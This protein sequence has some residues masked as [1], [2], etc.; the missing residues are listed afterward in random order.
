MA[1]GHNCLS[2]MPAD[3]PTAYL[4]AVK[5]LA[6]RELSVAQMRAR[7]A[8]RDHPPADV[9]RAVNLLLE[10]GAL[11]DAR[12][13]RAYA[14]TALRTKGRG[15]LRI[16]R[17]LH[18]IGIEKDVAGEALGEIFGEVDER[19]LIRKAI[20]KKLRGHKKIDSPAAYARMYQFLMRQGFSPSTVTAVLRAYR[21]GADPLE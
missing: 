19:A 13:A 4:D 20:E 16:Q 17:E 2:A 9:D 8:D 11:N 15:R 1:F 10:N 6:R 3:K 14:T 12:V 18:A 5:L 21:K 7:L